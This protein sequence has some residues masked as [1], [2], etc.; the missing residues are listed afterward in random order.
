MGSWSELTIGAGVPLNMLSKWMDH[1]S[2]E[3][4]TIYVNAPTAIQ[5]NRSLPIDRTSI[6]VQSTAG[7]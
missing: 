4:T 2:L 1:G 6:E 5:R 3:V 7:R